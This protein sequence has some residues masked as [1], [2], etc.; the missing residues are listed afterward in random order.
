VVALRK[1]GFGVIG[2]DRA[3]VNSVVGALRT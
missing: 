1:G 3:V 2:A